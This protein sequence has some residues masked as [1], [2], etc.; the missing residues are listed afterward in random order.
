MF[1]SQPLIGWSSFA[2]A[3][4][5][6]LFFPLG[7]QSASHTI[8]SIAIVVLFVIAAY[9]LITVEMIP[10]TW[11]VLAIGLGAGLIAVIIRDIR[12]FFRFFHGKVYRV[13][14]PY[15]WYS[16]AFRSLASSRRRTR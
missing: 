9:N 7:R 5:F 10:E 13:T 1:I 15:Y 16:R 4:V 11:Q 8:S 14:H 2:L 3:L 6:T 12:R